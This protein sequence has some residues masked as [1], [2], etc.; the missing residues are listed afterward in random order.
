MSLAQAI[1]PHPESP[2][3][4]NPQRFVNRMILFLLLAALAAAGAY[5]VV[6]R[7]FLYNPLLNGL[8]LGVLLVGII[9]IFRRVLGLKPEI[10]WIEE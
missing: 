9:Y 2:A 5:E 10:R 1:A 4:T 7:T 6:F 8:I 3:M